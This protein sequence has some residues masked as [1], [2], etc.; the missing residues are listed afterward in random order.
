MS[1]MFESI[2]I[3][4]QNNTLDNKLDTTD[5]NLIR[6]NDTI[7]RIVNN[8]SN[9]MF[10]NDD[11]SFID[12]LDPV[13]FLLSESRLVGDGGD[14]SGALGGGDVNTDLQLFLNPLKITDES[15]EETKVLKEMNNKIRNFGDVQDIDE[16]GKLKTDLNITSSHFKA[17]DNPSSDH[18]TESPI[19]FLTNK[20]TI[21]ETELAK[22]INKHSQS[23]LTGDESLSKFRSMIHQNFLQLSELN[24]ALHELY[25]TILSR[26]LTLYQDFEDWDSKR[27]KVLAKVKF[28]KSDKDING[29]KLATLIEQDLAINEEIS[30]LQNRI[31]RLQDSKKALAKEIQSTTSIIESKTSKYIQVFKQLEKNGLQ[32]V[33]NF[34]K[35]NSEDIPRKIVSM[36]KVDT[37]FDSQFKKSRSKKSINNTLLGNLKPNSFYSPPTSQH[38]NL[39]KVEKLK[40]DS[41]AVK[42]IQDECKG[43]E[44]STIGMKPYVFDEESIGISHPISDKTQ[45][46]SIQSEK[47]HSI[48]NPAELN[49]GHGPT[50]FELGY[51]NGENLGQNIKFKLKNMVSNLVANLP[52]HVELDS[53]KIPYVEDSSN[54]ITEKLDYDPIRVIIGLKIEALKSL[55]HNTSENATLYHKASIV[56]QDLIKI[57]NQQESKLLNQISES[58]LQLGDSSKSFAAILRLTLDKSKNLFELH[59]LNNT[60]TARGQSMILKVLSNESRAICNAYIMVSRC[61]SNQIFKEFDGFGFDLNSS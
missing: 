17:F 28:L 7:D 22:N 23:L 51:F 45:Q 61:S 50:P 39:R 58:V 53:S 24:Y 59:G 13:E 35:L 56:W 30:D 2:N 3:S 36:Q 31:Y 57:L 15:R 6:S 32:A 54:L 11:D 37:S 55:I 20:N 34:F 12:D 27:D 42:S 48:K 5:P 41:S 47:T 26:N 4:L 21:L 29:N 44:Q 49:H 38:D 18:Q 1:E 43:Q 25:T 14:L 40:M 10:L 33:E 16:I 19:K 60:K 8:N 52:E 9:K 46:N